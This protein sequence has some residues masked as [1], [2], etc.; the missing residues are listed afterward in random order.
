MKLF[1][2]IKTP[3]NGKTYEFEV[4][5]NM[6]VQKA[7]LRFIKEIKAFESTLIGFDEY[8][9]VLCLMRTERT[10]DD[11]LPLRDAGV[12]SGDVLMLI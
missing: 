12:R 2:E 10:L 6:A 3:G 4:S 9:S 1:I 11:R 5:D 7:K 8:A